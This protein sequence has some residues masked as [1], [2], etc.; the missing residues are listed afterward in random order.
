MLLRPISIALK[1]IS[2]LEDLCVPYFIGSS[3]ASAIYGVVRATNDVDIVAGLKME[4]VIPFK[5]ALQKE[6]YIDEDM[7]KK[8]IKRKSSFNLIYLELMFKVDVFILTDHHYDQEQ[9]KRR[10]KE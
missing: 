1:V 8:A 7:I 10:Y 4:H 9:L 6:F 5:E 2:V 3:L